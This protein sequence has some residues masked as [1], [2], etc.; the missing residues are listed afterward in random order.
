M[1]FLR[2]V[3]ALARAETAFVPATR[4]LLLLQCVALLEE[5]FQLFGLLCDAV[6]VAVFVLGAGEGGRL[7]NQLPDIVARDRDAAVDLGKRQVRSIGHG[8]SL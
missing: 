8:V 5:P 4:T 2:Q 3:L 7:L 1:G 6:G